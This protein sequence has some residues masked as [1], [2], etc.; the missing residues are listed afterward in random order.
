MLDILSHLSVA[1]P[2]SAR[3]KLVV[4]LTGS[5][6][7]ATKAICGV[8]VPG[9]RLLTATRDRCLQRCR[10][11]VTGACSYIG[12]ES[13]TS[14]CVVAVDAGDCDGDNASEVPVS[15]LAGC[16][17]GMGL[18]SAGCAVCS[19]GT[20]SHADVGD[21][22]GAWVLESNSTNHL[23]IASSGV[24]EY[25]DGQTGQFVLWHPHP[26]V[27]YP[28]C[29]FLEHEGEDGPTGYGQGWDYA[30][31][32]DGDG[33][34]VVRR[35]CGLGPTAC[36]SASSPEGSAQFEETR[37]YSPASVCSAITGDGWGFTSGDTCCDAAEALTA[38]D[39]ASA[40]ISVNGTTWSGL[41]LVRADGNEN[42]TSR[43]YENIRVA[44]NINDP[45]LCG[46]GPFTNPFDS[47]EFALVAEL[48]S[49]DVAVQVN[50]AAASGASL[51]F[52][53]NE[54]GQSMPSS[55]I[56]QGVLDI[57]M[58]EATPGAEILEALTV[59]ENGAGTLVDAGE[60][61]WASYVGRLC[62]SQCNASVIANGNA[63]ILSFCVGVSCAGVAFSDYTTTTVS[64]VSVSLP[65]S[66]GLCAACPSNTAA[67]VDGKAR[68]APCD[69][70]FHATSDATG[71]AVTTTWMYTTTAELT[72]T[73][74][75]S[76]DRRRR[77]AYSVTV[78]DDE[79]P[80]FMIMM[81]IVS[82]CACCL[83]VAMVGFWWQSS[84]RGTLNVGSLTGLVSVSR[85]HADSNGATSITF[86]SFLRI[87]MT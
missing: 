45:E 60:A 15:D 63:A 25:T 19:A 23:Y 29:F 86:G 68:C 37:T 14:L 70:G 39:A 30:W 78:E 72:T 58:L 5:S 55:L 7:V 79:V 49:C 9:A 47:G 16:G 64:T 36:G 13:V 84:Q 50:A 62:C 67:S 87:N 54:A 2:R 42:A 10:D 28:G 69:T 65:N 83:V 48:G 27:N 74:T 18:T 76:V 33:S 71:C 40:T 20:A 81:I 34:L 85:G 41:Q 6:F 12:Y 38:A 61:G 35:F 22:A 11:D 24:A 17:Y 53:T 26:D 80:W 32:E 56:V 43:S 73:G 57:W 21:L 51:L 44:V 77:A 8:H 4:L 3:V 46:S 66:E 82:V 75:T 31:R 1:V 59:A 52:I